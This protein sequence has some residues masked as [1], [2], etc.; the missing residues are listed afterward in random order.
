MLNKF[1]KQN[2]FYEYDM[3]DILNYFSKLKNK[4]KNLNI[5]QLKKPLKFNT[6]LSWR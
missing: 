6:K 4:P 2:K 3:D 1:V 5:V